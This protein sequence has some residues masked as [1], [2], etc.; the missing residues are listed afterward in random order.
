[1]TKVQ[2]EIKKKIAGKRLLLLGGSLW[3]EAIKKIA[4]EYEITLVAT[5]NSKKAGIFEIADE[6]YEVN[7]TD[8][9]AMKRLIIDKKLDGVYMG[10]NENVIKSACAYLE[11]LNMPCYCKKEQWEVLQDKRK[12]K[13]LCMKHHLPVALQYGIQE[14]KNR[15]ID[16][17]VITKPADGCGSSGF[18]VCQNDYELEIGIEKAKEN[19]PTNNIIIEKYVKNDGVVVFYTVSGGKLYFCGLEDKYPVRYEKQGSYVGG[20]FVF[21]SDLVQEFRQKFEN[22]LADLVKDIGIREGSFW[23]EVFHDGEKY[24]FN[25]A[26][27]RYGGSASIYPIDYMYGINQVAADIYYALTGESLIYG[28]VSIVPENVIRKK[29][30]AVY[31]IYA[32]KGE[33]VQVRGVSEVE[34]CPECITFI[35]K[36]DKGDIIMDSGT[37]SQ[38]A[39]LAHFVFDN[40]YELKSFIEKVHDVYQLLDSNDQNLVCNM[41]DIKNLSLK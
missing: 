25:E 7:S 3:K 23:I 29:Y 27:Y 19:S 38:V 6:G 33:I 21:E 24:Y 30:Y 18:T 14:I 2:N 39:A 10:G 15:G 32:K 35:T 28:F 13:A 11:E 26:G 22:N 17:P 40:E 41:L 8:A 20:L 12:F 34:Q 9:S 5:G 37:F 4:S 36:M 1:M 31:P 16:Y